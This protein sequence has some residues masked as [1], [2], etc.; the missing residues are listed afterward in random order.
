MVFLVRMNVS[1]GPRVDTENEED[2][3]LTEQ[4]KLR[5][6]Q[7][8]KTD[9]FR[10]ELKDTIRHL[11]RPKLD[12]LLQEYVHPIFIEDVLKQFP[13]FQHRVWLHTDDSGT[14]FGLSADLELDV[15]FN[16]EE[17][18][19]IQIRNVIQDTDI[20]TMLKV[21]NVFKDLCQTP[22]LK[23]V[24]VCHAIHPKIRR[25]AERSKIDVLL[26]RAN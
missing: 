8:I 2:D 19:L 12:T 4:C 7:L 5:L 14:A 23:A 1:H 16:D 24:V 22:V 20:L 25:L 15:F 6:L 18:Y 11:V 9:Q 3:L 26:V 21:G 10:E 17:T 13:G